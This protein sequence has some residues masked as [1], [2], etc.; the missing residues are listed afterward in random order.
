M[1]AERRIRELV[2]ANV[3]DNHH[4]DIV[5]F[6][7]QLFPVVAEAGTIRCWQPS[8]GKLCFQIGDQPAWEVELGRAHSKLR[9]MCARL[10]VIC[11][12]KTGLDLNFY[13]DE[14]FVEICTSLQP[15]DESVCCVTKMH[16]RFRNSLSEPQSFLIEAI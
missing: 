11:R 6:I 3:I 2:Q 13:G 10:A 1:N 4:V 15:E 14:A 9:M 16:I 5:R 8:A 7:D 12:E